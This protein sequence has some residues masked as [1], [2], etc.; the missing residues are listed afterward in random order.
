METDMP[1]LEIL[2]NTRGMENSDDIIKKYV[3]M[4]VI[5]TEA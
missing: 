1:D 3:C 5:I 4:T 2:K